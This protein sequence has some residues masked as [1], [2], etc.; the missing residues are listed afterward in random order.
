MCLGIIH[1]Y[2][3]FIVKR[4]CNSE[5]SV[6]SYSTNQQFVE[7][8]SLC[9]HVPLYYTGTIEQTPKIVNILDP[10]PKFVGPPDQ[11]PYL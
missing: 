6:W 4:F 8:L 10:S 3:S 2:K 5:S 11:S 1:P 9:I 7:F